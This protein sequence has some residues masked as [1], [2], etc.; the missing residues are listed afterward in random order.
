MH[1]SIR[2]S[3]NAFHGLMDGG[4]AKQWQPSQLRTLNIFLSGFCLVCLEGNIIATFM[5]C[6]GMFTSYH[7]LCHGSGLVAG[8]H[9]KP[10][11]SLEDKLSHLLSGQQ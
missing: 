1:K 5:F 9:M 7:I 11:V 3:S 8:V 4:E 2:T 10:F 6:N